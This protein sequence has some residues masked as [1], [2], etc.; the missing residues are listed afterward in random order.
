MRR[1]DKATADVQSLAKAKRKQTDKVRGWKSVEFIQ[2]QVQNDPAFKRWLREQD[3][4]V[5]TYMNSDYRG[6]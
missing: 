3:E 4:I 2:T 6:Y 1:K 5:A